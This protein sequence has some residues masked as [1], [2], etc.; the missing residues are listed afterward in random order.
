MDLKGANM[1]HFEDLDIESGVVLDR[2][3]S[4]DYLRW[5][6]YEVFKNVMNGD[7][8]LEGLEDI[9]DDLI[10]MIKEIEASNYEYFKLFAHPMAASGINY[11]EMKDAK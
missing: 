2:E 1:T 8:E 9:L 10:T 6:A 3:D 4:A 5:Q 7:E 11:I